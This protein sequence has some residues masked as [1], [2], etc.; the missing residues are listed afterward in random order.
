MMHQCVSNQESKIW[1]LEFCKRQVDD[2]ISPGEIQKRKLETLLPG[3]M[4]EVEEGDARVPILLVHRGIEDPGWDLVAPKGWAM[5]LLHLFQYAGCRAGSLQTVE[6]DRFESG[7]A[8]EVFDFPEMPIYQSLCEAEQIRKQKIF[9]TTPKRY[10]K[11][12]SWNGFGIDLS[13][14]RGDDVVVW[15]ST[16]SIGILRDAI[17]HATDFEQCCVK[18]LE[19]F[20]SLCASR[21]KFPNLDLESI[22]NSFLRVE[23]KMKAGKIGWNS[24]IHK[25]GNAYAQSGITVDTHDYVGFVLRGSFSQSEGT[26][27]GIGIVSLQ[28][29]FESKFQV[30]IRTLTGKKSYPAML[31]MIP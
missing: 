17:N 29:L 20:Q 27:R 8:T 30:A 26:P 5:P 21:P 1:D 9:N 15:H 11:N 22:K 23:V 3:T 24:L 4:L 12:Y 14:L 10:R 13:P 2:R 7:Q 16:R 18:I 25:N 19:E 31:K 28:R 6:V